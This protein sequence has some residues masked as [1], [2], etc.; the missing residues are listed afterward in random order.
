[1]VGRLACCPPLLFR[2][3]VGG[4][5]GVGGGTASS[6]VVV[7]YDWNGDAGDESDAG[8]DHTLGASAQSSYFRVGYSAERGSGSSSVVGSCATR[9]AGDE[10]GDRRRAVDLAGGC[11]GN[12]Y[13]SLV[14]A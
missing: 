2:E 11:D 14:L 13:R 9:G 7:D 5:R 8:T 4:G 6:W 3:G 10:M 12:G 1:M